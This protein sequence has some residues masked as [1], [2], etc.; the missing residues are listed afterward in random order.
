MLKTFGQVLCFYA[1]LSPSNFPSPLPTSLLPLPSHTLIPKFITFPSK[2]NILLMYFPTLVKKTISHHTPIHLAS[3][4][5]HY[6]V[7]KSLIDKGMSPSMEVCIVV[8]LFFLFAHNLH[9][10]TISPTYS[11]L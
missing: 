1:P 9:F 5:G 10:G 3:R 11:N 8:C 7:V 6:A 4:N 2:V